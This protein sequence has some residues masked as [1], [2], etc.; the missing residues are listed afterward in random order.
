MTANKTFTENCNVSVIRARIFS[1][2]S[3]TSRLP[4][5]Y[6]VLHENRF[7][8]IAGQD[9]RCRAAPRQNPS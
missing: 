3:S 5:C 6:M 8:L 1:F 9:G 7:Q 4:H 2:I